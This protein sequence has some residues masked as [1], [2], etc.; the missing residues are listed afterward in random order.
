MKAFVKRNL[1]TAPKPTLP[2]DKKKTK[3]WKKNAM[4]AEVI[5]RQAKAQRQRARTGQDRIRGDSTANRRR[6]EAVSTRNKVIN[7]SG[8]GYSEE[9]I[10]V[11]TGV[12]VDY[13][14]RILLGVKNGK[15]D[16]DKVMELHAKGMLQKDIAEELGCS[17]QMV[18][19]V[20]KWRKG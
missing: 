18:G 14:H 16:Y 20:I 2:V 10:A 4:I 3:E 11:E 9:R 1:P 15:L 5:A 17:K 19:K 12:T 8:Q 6:G 7:L 13:V